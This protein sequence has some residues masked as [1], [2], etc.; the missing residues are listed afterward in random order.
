MNKILA[1]IIFLVF[2]ASGPL[3]AQDTTGVLKADSTFSIV[4]STMVSEERID[5]VKK[6]IQPVF[7]RKWAFGLSGGYSY[8][9]PN[10][11]ARTNT[12]Y[13]KYLRNLK[14]GYSIGA[15]IYRFILP[16]VALGMKYNLF[17]SQGDFDKRNSDDITVQFV[18]PSVL[19]QHPF[20]N[21]TTSVLASFAMGYQSYVNKGMSD[22]KDFT[23]R[24]NAMGWAVSVGLEQKLGNHFALNISGACYLGTSYKFRRKMG[25]V[26]ETI[27][28]SQEKF[29]DLSRVELTLGLKFF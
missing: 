18:G 14:S 13:S 27:K 20:K 9:L 26:T 19:Y 28:L 24:G 11:G 23:N 8:R 1:V 22:S 4:D 16:Q 12:P 7:N 17:K 15:D 29:E 10:K 6:Q 2:L 21:N 25:G 5:I 3:K